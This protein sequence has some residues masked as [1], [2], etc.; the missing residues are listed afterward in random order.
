M[1]SN[2]GTQ[3]AQKG[4]TLGFR[5]GDREDAHS[6]MQAQMREQLKQTFRPEFLNRVDEVIIFHTLKPEHI[7]AIVDLQMK[8]IGQRL[9]ERGITIE[10]TEEGREWLAQKGYDPTFGA[11]PLKRLLQREVE[12]PLSKQI[13]RG[14]LEPG[15]KVVIEAGEE[16]LVFKKKA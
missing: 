12:S 7:K 9:A 10:L 3:Y 14:E 13:L 11:R 15:E 2:I 4:G 16:G 6:A 8:D 1:T 5:T